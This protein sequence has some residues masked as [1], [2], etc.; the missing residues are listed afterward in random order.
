MESPRVVVRHVA[1]VL[2]DGDD[3]VAR[4]ERAVAAVM[5]GA[6]HVR[7]LGGGS[8]TRVGSRIATRVADA[9]IPAAVDAQLTR[10]SRYAVMAGL[11]LLAEAGLVSAAG[12]W[13]LPPAERDGTAVL[14]A[15]SFEHHEAALRSARYAARRDELGRARA[16]LADV[17]GA[18]ARLDGLAAALEAEGGADVRKV[19]LQLL[20]GA[21]VQ[22]AQIVKARG[23]NTFV[24]C[25]CASTAAALAL[26]AAVLRAGEARRVVV[27]ACDTLLQPDADVVVESFVRL[28]A[29]STAAA[30][31]D[32]VRPFGE[33]RNGFVLG[34]GAVALLLERDGAPAPPAAPPAAP[35]V[36]VLAS[37][38]ANS[39]YHGTRLDGAHLAEV[40]GG[41]VREACERRGGLALA[42]FAARAIYVSH[43]TFT[44]ACA[45]AEVSA[46]EAVFGRDG[47][48][49]LTIA[50]TKG[51]TGHMMGSGMED[52][53]SVEAL[54][55]RAC[56]DARVGAVDPAF[57]DLR[58]AD[59]G[60]GPFDFAVHLAAG[61]GSHVA[62]VVYA[63]MG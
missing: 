45:P 3:A 40:L 50:S 5:Q 49:A 20:L 21:N 6:R 7:G 19:A 54:R 30:V 41:C 12:G 60:A 26:A 23:L 59:G 14:F 42:A 39:A 52:V 38:L 10:S 55:T 43:E 61:M 11:D 33:G 56:P 35:R 27:V 1:A 53:V 58:F 48:R 31:D 15:S 37:R 62:V 36:E 9:R 17:P 51:S 18:A 46:L 44:P 16:A 24:T 8:A 28:R 13:E 29:A 4:G 63:L 34:D 57:A 25:A 2:P 47:L 22:L 32:A